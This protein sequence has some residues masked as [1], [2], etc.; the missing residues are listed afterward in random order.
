VKRRDHQSLT[1]P[2]GRSVSIPRVTPSFA[3]GGANQGNFL[4][5]S[6]CACRDRVHTRPVIAVISLSC[7]EH[8]E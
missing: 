3:Y 6:Y 4:A 1:S 8:S 2:S 7:M 5:Q